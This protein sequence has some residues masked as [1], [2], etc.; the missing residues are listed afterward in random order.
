MPMIRT[1]LA[2]VFA[3]LS[4]GAA[5]AETAKQMRNPPANM[6][7]TTLEKKVCYYEDADGFIYHYVIKLGLV[8]QSCAPSIET[9]FAPL[10][11]GWA[12]LL[13]EE[14]EAHG[15]PLRLCYYGLAHGRLEV[16]RSRPNMGCTW[17][18]GHEYDPPTPPTG[19]ADFVHEEDAAGTEAKVCFFH[20]P[21]ARHPARF[22]HY[23]TISKYSA[24]P[25]TFEAR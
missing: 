5:H 12:V 19:N 21:G 9:P 8:P 7:G 17:T 22:T 4:L 14:V 3:L 20:L 13:K 16:E 25:K 11:P 6:P 18:A 23:M 15:G 2:A 1:S 24:C 10:P